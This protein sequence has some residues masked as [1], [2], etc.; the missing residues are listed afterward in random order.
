MCEVYESSGILYVCND[1][2]WEETWLCAFGFQYQRI[3][4]LKSLHYC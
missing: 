1:K 2:V 3:K 4:C